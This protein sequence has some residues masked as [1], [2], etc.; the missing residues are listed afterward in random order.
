MTFMPP[1]VRPPAPV[2][3]ASILMYLTAA[4]TLVYAGLLVVRS[5]AEYEASVGAGVFDGLDDTYQHLV[6]YQ[7]LIDT[8]FQVVIAAAFMLL[9]VL[10]TRRHNAAR[11][12]TWILAGYGILSYALFT[13]T[14]TIF[15]PYRDPYLA[16]EF[17]APPPE[18]SGDDPSEW[19]DPAA[20]VPDWLPPAELVTMVILLALHIA[21]VAL[22]AVPAANR[23]FWQPPRWLPWQPANPYPFL[24]APV[25]VSPPDPS[26]WQPPVEPTPGPPQ[27][28][29]PH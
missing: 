1:P 25:P 28:P 22:L 17:A 13:T 20:A 5:V 8:F 9:A 29:V 14:L 15:T 11:V 2:R 16:A 12:V 23:Y 4:V 27:Q 6:W 24:Y 19:F 18:G 3:T 7:A 10:I 21:L 26:P